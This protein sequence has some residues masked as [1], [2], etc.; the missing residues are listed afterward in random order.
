MLIAKQ[1]DTN[2]ELKTKYDECEEQIIKLKNELEN[3]SSDLITSNKVKNTLMS[4]INGLN[5]KIELLE[6]NFS[7]KTDNLTDLLNLEKE[8]IEKQKKRREF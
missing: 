8:N 4:E 6:R 5:N 3:K 2:N 7:L 1:R